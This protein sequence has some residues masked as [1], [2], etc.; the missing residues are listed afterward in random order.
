MRFLHHTGQS[1][2]S[3]IGVGGLR[4]SKRYLL[5]FSIVLGF[6]AIAASEGFAQ[7]APVR[8]LVKLKKDDGTLV[9][10]PDALVEP[11]RIDID[12]G[13][14]PS[15]KTN[16]NGEFGFVG[17]SLANKYVLAISGRRIEAYD[18][19]RR[20]GRDGVNLEILVFPGDGKQ[21]T[22][23]E[24]RTCKA[25][26]SGWPGTVRSRPKEGRGR[27]SETSRKSYRSE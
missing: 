13:K 19:K 21:L 25:R 2:P 3:R 7:T 18:L 11:Y 12:S 20:Q 22:E 16:K 23:A 15:T 10:V 5:L 26:H 17:F 4:M 1:D 14:S 24:A 6:V 8:G 9:P 27:V